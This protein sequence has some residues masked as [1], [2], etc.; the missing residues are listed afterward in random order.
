MADARHRT[1]SQRFDRRR[2]IRATSRACSKIESQLIRVTAPSA[3]APAARADLRCPARVTIRS[4]PRTSDAFQRRRRRWRRHHGDEII[5]PRLE[6]PQRGLWMLEQADLFNLLCIPPFTRDAA[7]VTRHAVWDAAATYCAGSSRS[8]DRR[9]RRLAGTNPPTSLGGA[10]LGTVVNRTNSAAIYFPRILAADPLKEF[11]PGEFRALRRD[12][13]RHRAH[14]RRTRRLEGAG[15][16]RRDPV[17][18]HRVVAGWRTGPAHGSADRPPESV[19][20]ELPAHRAR[21]PATSCGARARCAARTTW[22]RN[23]NTCRCGALALF[24]RGEPVPR[25]AV[26]GVRTQ[27]RAAV[28]AAAAELRR[29]HAGPVPAGRVPGRE[30]ARGLLREVLARDH[31]AGRHRRRH[32]QHAD[33]LRAAQAGRVRRD[34]HPADDAAAVEEQGRPW[35]NSAST[36]AA[37]ILTRTSS[38]G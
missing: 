19:R 33:R 26:G 11:R 13:R 16:P 8:A 3:R 5:G 1:V 7:D 24:H 28:G 4:P 6:A 14:R 9:S 38:S 12:R 27:R 15:R 23:G 20:R 37:S 29:V 2:R 30:P 10:A 34:P 25:H 31:D 35:L 21:T 17:R 22:H 32:R 36:P 18:R